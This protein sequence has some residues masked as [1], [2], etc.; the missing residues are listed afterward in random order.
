LPRLLLAVSGSHRNGLTLS[1]DDLRECAEESNRAGSAPLTVGH[2]TQASPQYG[3]VRNF[4]AEDTPDPQDPARTV[5]GLFADVTP[6]PALRDAVRGGFFRQRSV[7]I[8]RHP[9]TGRLYTHHLAVLGATPPAIAGLPELDFS[10]P[11]EAEEIRVTVTDP[12]PRRGGDFSDRSPLVRTLA[13]EINRAAETDAYAD[14]DAVVA[15]MAQAAGVDRATVQ[16]VLDGDIP[17]PRHEWLRG[18]ARALD[19]AEQTLVDLTDFWYADV[20]A[21]VTDLTDAPEDPAETAMPNGTPNRT[22]QT[23]TDPNAA[24]A[25]TPETDAQETPERQD[26]ADVSARL[27]RAEARHKAGQLDALEAAAAEALGSGPAAALRDFAD[28]LVPAGADEMDFADAPGAEPIARLTDIL[29]GV[30]SAREHETVVMDFSAA[31][32]EESAADEAVTKAATK[33]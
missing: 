1:P 10:D 12:G 31:T 5:T 24:P 33:F 15:A 20:T 18:F 28:T 25:G 2:V 4:A 8:R 30:A 27:Q 23:E 16:H 3:N 21:A 32:P 9:S 19:V 17:Y 11:E 7:G 29:R 14:R 22:P 6:V 13:N 26:F